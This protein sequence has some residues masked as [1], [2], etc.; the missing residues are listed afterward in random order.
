M[1]VGVHMPT[2]ASSAPRFRVSAGLVWFTSGAPWIA[3]WGC[4]KPNLRPSFPL[5]QTARQLERRRFC[6]VFC[7]NAL[8]ASGRK[9]GDH[10]RADV[11]RFVVELPDRMTHA[12]EGDPRGIRVASVRSAMRINGRLRQ[13]VRH[14]YGGS[15]SPLSTEA[16]QRLR[17]MLCLAKSVRFIVEGLLAR[18]SRDQATFP[19]ERLDAR[20]A[21]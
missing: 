13:V 11:G 16:G 2:G 12:K 15:K 19:P 6:H 4:E 20:S 21:I 18:A 14:R 1:P 9:H 7:L 3:R 17:S 5:R 8:T 10:R